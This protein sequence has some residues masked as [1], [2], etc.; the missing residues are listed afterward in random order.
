MAGGVT[1]GTG[2]GGHRTVF[3]TERPAVHRA[4]ALEAAPPALDVEMLVNPDRAELIEALNGAEF[5]ISER[6]G[7]IDAE[8]IAAGR[9]LRLIQRLGSRSH[10]IDLAAAQAAGVPVC[11]WPMPAST[12]VAEHTMM[13]VLA[14]VKRLRDSMQVFVAGGDWGPPCRSDANTFVINWAKRDG[15]VMLRGR[16]VGIV[17]MGEI[18]TT[19]AAY[20]NALG[21]EV[22]YHN[23][24]RLPAAVENREAVQYRALDDLLGECDVVCLLLPA[25][26]ETIGVT[27]ANFLAKMRPGALLVSCGASTTLDE[28]AVADAYIGGH[29][30]GVATDGHRWEPTRDDDPLVVLSRDPT[31]NVVLTPHTA[32]ADLRLTAD[33]RKPEFTNLVSVLEGRP[34]LH[35]V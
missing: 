22:R 34:L 19:L 29:L 8:I 24:R 31:A 18:G 14:L 7:V 1:V 10:D 6:V 2:G 11:V 27:D 17:G 9:S 33:H 28:Q 15:I 16:T 20:L 5:L 4:L 13:L 25:A 12:M 23:R 30:G 26:P 35:Q 3:T 21:A 32:Q